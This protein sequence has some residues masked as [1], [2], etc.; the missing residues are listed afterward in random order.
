MFFHIRA[1][2]AGMMRKGEIRSTRTMARPGNASL[3]SSPSAVPS[4]TVTSITE[5]SRINVF[6][7][8]GRNEAS[9]KKKWKLASPWKGW[10]LGSSME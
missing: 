8:A 4:T 7:K 6:C 9:V 1:F 10:P 3:I 5:N 2:T